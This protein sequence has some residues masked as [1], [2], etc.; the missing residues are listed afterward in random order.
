[1]DTTTASPSNTLALGNVFLT[2]VCGLL[3]V[4]SFVFNFSFLIILLK[5]RRLY[6]LDKSNFLLTHMIL[7]DFICAFMVLVPSGYSIFNSDTI[8][9]DSGCHVQ[10]YFSTFFIC[11]SF[12]GL[13][14]LS[15]ERF[16]KYKYPIWHINNFTQRLVFDEN[17]RV[18]NQSSNYKVFVIIAFSWGIN[19]FV[20]FIPLFRNFNDVGY[21]VLQSQCDYLYEN[22]NWWIWIF[23]VYVTF[24]AIGALIFF[25]ITF[26]LIHKAERVIKVQ[27]SQ[28]D[29]EDSEFKANNLN[30]SEK[31]IEGVD[32]T[33]Q[34]GNK[35]YYKH[36]L[37]LTNNSGDETESTDFHVRNQLLTQYKYD[38]EKSKTISFLIIL[39]VSYC[40]L[41]PIFV[42]HFYR[43]Y[44]N[45]NNGSTTDNPFDNL[46][47]VG[48][49]TYTAFVWISYILLV[50]KSFVCLVQN[51]F[52]RDALY[53]SANCRGFSG[54][55]DF[56][57]KDKVNPNLRNIIGESVKTSE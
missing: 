29:S 11:L 48:K 55:F 43:T 38:T 25:S 1:M 36:I 3:L 26:T 19:I 12:Q 9:K 57:K 6:R 37:D 5:M 16:I 10:T 56:Q 54:S 7:A 42:I 28:F 4:L 41:F 18:I 39:I 32:I 31:I 13:F 27:K 33:N 22:F 50:V 45:F 47:V 2:V 53:Q 52:Y 23:Y 44:N 49:R 34:P 20:S 40:L 30:R 17:D 8:E 35:I 14:L 24:H 51:K 15:I 21:F 46:T